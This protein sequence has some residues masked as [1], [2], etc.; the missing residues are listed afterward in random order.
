MAPPR[1]FWKGYL[2]LSLVTCPV[3]MTPAITEGEKIRF[4][5]LNR[6]TG[7][8]IASRY[9]DSVTGR[10]VTDD[11]EVMGYETAKDEFVQLEEDELDAVALESTRT[12][13]IEQFV[14][15]ESIAGIWR[16][17]PHYLVPDDPVGEEAF[18]VIRQGMATT[19]TAGLSRLVLYRRERRVM[20]EPRDRGI[21]LWTLHDPA[22]IRDADDYFGKLKDE[23]APKDMVKVAQTVIA[24]RT[25]E[26]APSLAGDRVQQQLQRI[27]TAK[28]KGRKPARAKASEPPDSGGNVISIMDALR[29]SLAGERKRGK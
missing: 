16:D 17:R 24:E 14:P 4:R 8:P 26:W 28:R 1:A 22:Q 23:P 9:V 13:D 3:A 29:R 12:I 10:P 15:R 25:R 2:K 6:A 18:A 19:G 27:I 7:N 20:L 11:D 21:L 5:T